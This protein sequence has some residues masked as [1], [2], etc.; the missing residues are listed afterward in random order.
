MQ[1][2]VAGRYRLDERLGI[3]GQ[4]QVFRGHDLVTGATVAVKL[5]EH[6][7]AE[8]VARFSLESRL[9]ARIRDP[10][11]VVA[12]H[13]GAS[14]GQNF[15]VFDYIPGVTPVTRMLESGRV[16]AARACELALQVLDALAS[17]HEAGVVHQ[18]VSPANCLWRERDS[19]RLE[20]FLIDLGSAA[21]RLPV[22]GGP[23]ASWEAV[24]TANYMAPEMMAGVAWDHRV[25]LWSVGALM[26]RLL[27]GHEVDI[28]PDEPLEIPPPAQ[29]VPGIP[30]AV[31]D[32]V[33]G[34][35]TDAGS[36]FPSATVMAA[37]IR[38]ALSS[39]APRVGISRLAA[40]GAVAVAVVVAVLGTLATQHALSIPGVAVRAPPVTPALASIEPAPITPGP[41]PITPEPA[42]VVLPPPPLLRDALATAT[43]ALRRC[44]ALA[45]GPLVV[46]FTTL[47]GGD[48]FD[49]VAVSGVSTPDLDRCV[50]D[51]TARLRF[52]PW[53]AAT[54][55]EDYEP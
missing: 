19:G 52:Q 37:A 53:G 23:A 1:Q 36:R 18:D 16:E 5:M 25:D 14:E 46:Q 55:T 2:V 32:V 35:L 28:D 34:A 17:L 26:Y 47:A 54:F 31:S 51:A 48:T 40:L 38:R 21:S 12:L 13:Y 3:G 6:D 43:G 50:H 42:P 24:G 4:A 20:V 27:T 44:S 33:M 30:R 41:A 49:T 7:S 10:H 8:S 9:A 29:R 11:L 22:T 15:I 39:L 45:G